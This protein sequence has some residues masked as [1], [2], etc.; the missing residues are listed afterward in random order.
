MDAWDEALKTSK[1]QLDASNSSYA[2]C[3]LRSSIGPVL[4]ERI[5]RELV[6]DVSGVRLHFFI[7]RKLQVSSTISGRQLVEKLQLIKLTAVAG[8]H[9]QDCA[10]K[11][12][13]VCTKLV[14]L[15]SSHVSSD[16]PM[17][18]AQCFETTGI[19]AFVLEVT[20]IEND[21]DDDPCS[22]SWISILSLQ[23]LTSLIRLNV[24]HPFRQRE[25]E[26]LVSPH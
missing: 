5:D 6:M 11:I 22:H 8:C 20:K 10:Q 16:L 19:Q 25:A 17:L 18:V 26:L 15:V 21:L 3:F 12:H 2:R 23:S 9:V 1:C 13:S 7:I 4:R 14:G 24:G